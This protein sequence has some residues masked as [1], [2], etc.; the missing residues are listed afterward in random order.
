MNDYLTARNV[1]DAIDAFLTDDGV[2]ESEK[3][4]LW[5]VLTALRGPGGT[6][7]ETV[8]ANVTAVIRANAFPK[9][10][11]QRIDN[12]PSR[13]L[14]TLRRLVDFTGAKKGHYRFHAIKACEALNLETKGLN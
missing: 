13:A 11:F 9:T 5:N 10:A 14:F 8:K 3:A 1:L 7:S 2:E 4:A 12:R 6:R